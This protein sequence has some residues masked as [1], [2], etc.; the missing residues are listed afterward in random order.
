MLKKF[1]TAILIFGI[2]IF[3][4][5]TSAEFKIFEGVGEHYMEDSTETLDAAKDKAKLAAELN[6]AEQVAVMVFSYSE[7]HNSNLTRDEIITIT[8]GILKVT[9]VKY[10][11]KSEN[12]G[13]LL[14]RA[15][16]TAEVDIDE[17][18]ALIEREIKRRENQN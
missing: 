10:A 14:M 2:L 12:D 4:T 13:T 16:V 5:V 9:D 15:V 8:A 7:M 3:A 1:M 18:P 17:V 11:L 6:I